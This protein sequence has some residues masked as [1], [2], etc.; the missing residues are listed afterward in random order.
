MLPPEEAG[1]RR[2]AGLL[3]TGGVLRVLVNDSPLHRLPEPQDVPGLRS[4]LVPAYAAAGLDLRRYEV[5]VVRP[6]ST[7]AGRLGQG[8]P[9]RV[10]R[11]E[12]EKR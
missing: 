6:E 11:V 7:W 3:R 9:L 2:I 5:A 10:M 4:G 1:L 12:A 8:R